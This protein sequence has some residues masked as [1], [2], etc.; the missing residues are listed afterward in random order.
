MREL[1]REQRAGVQILPAIYF[2]PRV[3]GAPRGVT[4]RGQRVHRRA[5]AEYIQEQGFIVP[6]PPVWQETGLRF[7]AVRHGCTAVQRPAPIDAVVERI[8][9][10]ADLLLLLRVSIEIGGGSQH[11]REE[12]RRI[13]RGQL[14]VAGAPPRFHVEEMVV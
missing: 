9:Q 3:R 8:R 7:P 1:M 4:L 11:P 14:A 5:Q 12:E 10:G 13:D 2:L 6:L